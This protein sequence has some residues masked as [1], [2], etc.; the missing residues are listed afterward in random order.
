MYPPDTQSH[1][2]ILLENTTTVFCKVEILCEF[3]QKC[4]IFEK[5][6]VYS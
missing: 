3:I 6:K 4:I 1:Q 2:P 5:K